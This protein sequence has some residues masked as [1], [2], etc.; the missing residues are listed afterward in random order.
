MPRLLLVDLLAEREA[1]GQFG[2][3]EIIRHFPKHDVFLWSPHSDEARDYPFGVRVDSPVDADVILITGSRR[4]VSQWEDWMDEV[5]SLIL[6]C[7]VPLYGICFG[8]QI[9][10][11]V[12]GGKVERADQGSDFMA[13]VAYLDGSVKRQLFTHQDHVVDAGEMQV[14]GSAEHCQIAV[15]KHPTRPIKTV[16]FHPEAVASVMQVALQCGDLSQAEFDCFTGLQDQDVS[17]SLLL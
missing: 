16:Q 5:A 3:A 4:N 6:T 9:I 10:C 1:F 17:Q 7:E 12:L 14:I 11:K 13:D 2:C 8:H 15:C